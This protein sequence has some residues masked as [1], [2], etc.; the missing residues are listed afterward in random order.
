MHVNWLIP[1][2]LLGVFFWLLCGMKIKTI[3]PLI[4][5][6]GEFCK[7][8]S[9]MVPEEC[10]KVLFPADTVWKTVVPICPK[11][12]EFHTEGIAPTF[13]LKEETCVFNKIW[14]ANY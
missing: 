3:N 4:Q 2:I 12:I 9:F 7:E 6:Q 13:F 11:Y 10:H 5:I 14:K 1:V 8:S